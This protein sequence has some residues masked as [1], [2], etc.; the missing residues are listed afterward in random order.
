MFKYIITTLIIFFNISI[1]IFPTEI[2]NGTKEGLEIWFYTLIPSLFPFVVLS[3]FLLESRYLSLLPDFIFYPIK[4]LLNI[5]TNTAKYYVLAL[6]TGYPLGAKISSELYIKQ[7]LSKKE[8]KHTLYFFN[9]CSIIFTIGTVGILFYNNKNLGI[10]LYT[11]HIISSYILGVLYSDR[12][13]KTYKIT[14][15][16]NKE[17]N[18]KTLFTKSITNS[19]YTLL[20]IGSFVIFFSFVSATL[21]ATGVF[22][23]ITL[24]LINQDQLKG[25][26]LGLLEFTNGIYILSTGEQNI[27]TLPLISF[28]LGFSGLSVLM[29]SI[30]FIEQT[31]ISPW[32]FIKGKIQHG[33]LAGF[34]TY[35]L[36]KFFYK[37]IIPTIKIENYHKHTEHGSFLKEHIITENFYLNP[38][39]TMI[40]VSFFITIIVFYFFFRNKKYKYY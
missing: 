23:K 37:N 6:L 9:N 4:K 18:I 3:T 39:Y 11:I 24:P 22:E 32:L 36:S 8:Y 25:I 12:T 7:D 20:N 16:F 26:F 33:L 15:Y 30:F 5:N 14:Q 34:L 19:F 1:F 27:L 40:I 17:E 31:K 21:D 10:F 29:Q 35:I 38:F 2:I 28:L 13:L